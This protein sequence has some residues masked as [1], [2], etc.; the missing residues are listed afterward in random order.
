MG[1]EDK[2]PDGF[3]AWHHEKG[4]LP[5]VAKTED[6]AIW[7]AFCQDVTQADPQGMKYQYDPEKSVEICKKALSKKGWKIRPVK[8]QFLDEPYE[9]DAI[10]QWRDDMAKVMDKQIGEM[11]EIKDLKLEPHTHRE[12]EFLQEIFE[13]KKAL[14]EAYRAGQRS[15]LT[16]ERAKAIGYEYP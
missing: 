8:L 13:L 9:K 4:F 2:K 6:A 14:K 7:W 1:N 12:A 3:V 5:E 15:V 16:D 11:C 10:A